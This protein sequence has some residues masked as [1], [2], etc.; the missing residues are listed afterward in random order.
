MVVHLIARSNYTA[1]MYMHIN[2]NAIVYYNSGEMS[3][4]ASASCIR[5]NK[6]I[7]VFRVA[8]PHLKFTD[9]T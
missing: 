1:N 9:K 7:P 3:S 8:R 6:K 2:S 5:P 4:W